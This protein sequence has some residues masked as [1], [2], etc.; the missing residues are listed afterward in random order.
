MYT[1]YV[2]WGG[3]LGSLKDIFSSRVGKESGLYRAAQCN[4]ERKN[5]ALQCGC[6][7]PAEPWV[8]GLVCSGHCMGE[9]ILCREGRRG[10]FSQITLRF[11]VTYIP[12]Q[13]VVNTFLYHTQTDAGAH[14]T[15]FTVTSAS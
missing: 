14:K 3:G 6:G 9:S 13:I 15:H 11:L 7:I 5:V 4:V 12:S 2:V 10:S 8:I 1:N